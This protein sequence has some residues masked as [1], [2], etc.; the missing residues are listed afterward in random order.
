MAKGGD[1]CGHLFVGFGEGLS[2]KSPVVYFA[3][4]KLCIGDDCKAAVNAYD[5]S[6]LPLAP[7]EFAVAKE[8]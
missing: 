8:G 1:E 3:K 2:T 5:V 4:T 7:S 6:L